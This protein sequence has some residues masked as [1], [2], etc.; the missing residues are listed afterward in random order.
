MPDTLEELALSGVLFETAAPSSRPHSPIS[1]TPSP[2]TDDE[3]FGALSRPVSPDHD[4]KGGEPGESIGMGPGRTGVK[5]VIRD[6]DEALERE[7]ARRIA[8][9]RER[10]EKMEK[11]AM[12]APGTSFFD[13]EEERRRRQRKE[14][15]GEEDSE[16]D[17]DAFGRSG[18]RGKGLSMRFPGGENA[19]G[20]GHL[21]EVGA[22]GFVQAVEQVDRNVWVV[23]HLY[24]PVRGMT[25]LRLLCLC[26]QMLIRCLI[27]LAR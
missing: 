27:W 25:G 21:R 24:H 8:E 4:E 10:Q 14:A 7:R 15:E 9:M 3:H 16:E 1:R 2:N 17:E 23:V 19:G 12:T 22:A 13:Q 6:R 20:F 11:N 5:G 18:Q 26:M